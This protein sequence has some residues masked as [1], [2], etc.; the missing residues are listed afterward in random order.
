MSVRAALAD[1]AAGTRRFIA[2]FEGVERRDQMVWLVPSD[3]E[4]FLRLTAA[5][6]ARWP[7]HEP[8]GGVH[9]KLVAHLTLLETT[10]GLALDQAMSAAIEMGPFD[11]PV[12]ELQL[13][14]EDTS[15]EWHPRWRLSMRA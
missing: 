1:L 9:E 3:Q 2:R 10:D 7:D 11:V 4:P 6:V 8:Y 12:E 14:A 15:G 5:V 13:I